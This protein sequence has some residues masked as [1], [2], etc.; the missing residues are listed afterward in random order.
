MTKRLLQLLLACSLAC[1][2]AATGRAQL[3]DGPGPP[4]WTQTA[5]ERSALISE[6]ERNRFVVRRVEFLGNTNTRHHV[7][8][9]RLAFQEGDLFAEA[10]LERSLRDMSRL[11]RIIKP[12]RLKDVQVRLNR[13]ERLIDLNILIRERRRP[14]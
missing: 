6:A 1:L 12:V 9:S 5:A 10:L 3:Q 8:A 13:E 4:R 14:K 11:S 2:A 7:L